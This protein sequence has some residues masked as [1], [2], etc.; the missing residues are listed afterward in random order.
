MPMKDIEALRKKI[1]QIDRSV[2]R[3]LML[4]IE[5]A[6]KI[7]KIKKTNNAPAL[8]RKREAQ[9]INNVKKSSQNNKFIADIYRR[10]I[11][12]SR[13]IQK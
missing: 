12:Y 5:T 10:I 13:K 3:L 1:D 7:G 11:E 4:R 9:V 8:D 6:R 2:A